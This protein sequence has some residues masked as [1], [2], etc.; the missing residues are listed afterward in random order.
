MANPKPDRE[1]RS[2]YE[3][4]LRLVDQLLIER[5]AA[6]EGST[7]AE[8]LRRLLERNLIK[9]DRLTSRL[10]LNKPPAN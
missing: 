1:K 7:R 3:F 4:S 8:Y 5:L 10:D 6:D 2:R 9:V